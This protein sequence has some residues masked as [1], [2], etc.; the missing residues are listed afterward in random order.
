[1]THQVETQGLKRG[2]WGAVKASR[3]EGLDL[4]ETEL[5]LQMGWRWSVWLQPHVDID[6][7][8]TTCLLPQLGFM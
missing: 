3:G 8:N 5:S 7:K 6:F 4:L 1:M 2:T